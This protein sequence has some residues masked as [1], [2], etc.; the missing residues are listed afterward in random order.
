MHSQADRQKQVTGMRCCAAFVKMS[1]YP[2]LLALLA[3]SSVANAGGIQSL[4]DIREAIDRYAM[5]HL[6]QNA[7]RDT[8]TIGRLDPRL[9][10]QECDQD[11]EAFRNP[12]NRRGGRSTVGV[13]CPGSQPWTIYVSVQVQSHASALAL[14]RAMGRGERIQAGDLRETEINV[15]DLPHGHYSDPERLVGMQLRRSVRAGEVLSPLLVEAPALVN[16]G[17]TVIVI[18]AAGGTEVS[19]QG[20]ALDSGA[21]GDRIRVRNSVSKRVIE[22]EIIERGRIRVML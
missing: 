14:T 12:G 19:M 10:L 16:R 13:R 11:I 15:A 8:V 4:D 20:E 1:T 22:G 18:A 17:E 2:V 6:V 9:R 3:I 21:L 7:E 5:E